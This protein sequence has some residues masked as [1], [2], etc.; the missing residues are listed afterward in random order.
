[1]WS[2]IDG[3]H[4]A[5][6][7]VLNKTVGYIYSGENV[8]KRKKPHLPWKKKHALHFYSKPKRCTRDR[9]GVK[10]KWF[11]RLG[12]IGKRSVDESSNGI[13]QN[14]PWKQLNGSVNVRMGLQLLI[15]LVEQAAQ[16]H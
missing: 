5:T 6:C 10:I 14:N 12:Q 8:L 13:A 3:S 2:S 9:I 16:I 11:S 15:E 4:E 1:M 7:C